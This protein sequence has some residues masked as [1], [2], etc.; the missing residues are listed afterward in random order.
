MAQKQTKPS[1][2]SSA[3]PKQIRLH[4]EMRRKQIIEAARG[5]LLPNPD[6][7]I[8]EVA[9]AAGVTRQL[10]SLYFPGGGTG[11]FFA[12]MFDEYTASLPAILGEEFAEA[13]RD[14]A[15][16]R[17]TTAKAVAS[18]LDWSEEMGQAWVFSGT[19]RPT[20]AGIAEKLELAHDYTVQLMIES[21]PDLPDTPA[22][23]AAII[24]QLAGT[25]SVAGRLLEGKISREAAEAALVEGFVALFAVVLPA[26]S[27]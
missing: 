2:K 10:V 6:A 16:V 11:P 5:I 13:P 18:F 15:D 19:S 4:P 3:K 20:G 9:E 14:G 26:L 22:V 23:R 25:I 8:E 17:R 27:A 12:A 1:A 24:C 7:T 21:R